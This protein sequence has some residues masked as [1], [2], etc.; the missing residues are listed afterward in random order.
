LRLIPA[1]VKPNHLTILRMILTV[2]IFFLEFTGMSLGWIIILGL[3]AG[4]SDLLDGFL[5]RHRGQITRLGALLDPVADKFFALA[6]ALLIW[7]RELAPHYLLLCFLLTE[8][9]A[10]LVP[11]GV[12][13]SRARAGRSLLPL[14]QVWP[15]R[16]GKRKTGWL[17]SG[18]GVLV[19]AAWA[20]LGWLSVVGLFGLWVALGLGLVAE[21]R[22]LADW[23]AGVYK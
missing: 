8:I 4:F 5:A 13:I 14:P 2:V 9:H 7:R 15:N 22:Y 16:W 12:M 18:L 23:R 20:G 6:L 3:M 21:I 1:G 17:A 19:I 11:A 10:V